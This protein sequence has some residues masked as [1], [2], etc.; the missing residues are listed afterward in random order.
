MFQFTALSGAQS[1]SRASQSILELDGGVKILVDIGWDERFDT[2]QL[3]EL[4]KHVSTLSFILLTHATISHL[5]AYAHCCK[6]IPLFSQVPVYATAPVIAFGR[7][8]LQDLYSSAPAAA[9]FIPASASPED[10]TATDDATR[11][12]ILREAPTFEEINTY[13]SAITPLKYSQPHQP[14]ASY[15]STPLEGLTLTAYNA[16]H[17]LGG[18]IWHIQHGMESIV[19]AV[20]WHQGRENVIAGA[21]WFEGI[22]GSDVSEALRKPTALVCNSI[23][24]GKKARD[25]ALLGHIRSCLSRGGSVLIPTDSS[26]RILE[27]AW[28][29]EKVW[30]EGSN[31]ENLKNAKV[32]MATKSAHATL[33]HARS[34]LEWM[35]DSIVREFEGEEENTNTT[36]KSH[37]RSKSKQGNA[38]KPLRPFEF[39]HVKIVETQNRLERVLKGE[40]PRVIV[41]SD[42]SAEWGY[43]RAALEHIAQNP[44]NVVI[45][46]ERV[47]T[48]STKDMATASTLGQWQTERLNGVALEKS[49]SGDQIE[50]IHTG[51]ELVYRE[52]KRV[53]LDEAELSKYQQY[54]ATQKQIRDSLLTSDGRQLADA[55]DAMAEDDESSSE[56]ED[57]EDEQQ[58]RV[59]NVSA[60]LT[61]GNRNKVALSDEDLGVSILLRKK[62]VFDFD[63]RNK[64]GRNAVFPYAHSR[65]RG[66]EFGDFIKPEDFLREEEREA[67]EAML[68]EKNNSVLGQKRKWSEDKTKQVKSNKKQKAEPAADGAGDDA[69]SDESDSDVE[70]EGAGTE[71][72]LPGKVIYEEKRINFQARLAFVDFAGLHDQ[73]GLQ[74]LIP[75]INPKKL[76][77]VGGSASETMSLANDCKA[78]LG[79]RVDGAENESKAE[80]YAPQVGDMIDASVDTN[81]WTVK[82]TRDLVK[83]LQWQNVRNMSIVTISGQLRAESTPTQ[84]EEEAGSKKLKLEDGSK[85]V[86][87][88]I[89][90]N[91]KHQIQPVLD[92]IPASAAASLRVVTQP[93]HVGDLRL[94]DL[95]RLMRES[96][97]SAVF[98]GEGTLLIDD[99]VAVRKLASGRIV[100]EGPPV[101]LVVRNDSFTQVKQKIY[102]GLA[103]VA[104]G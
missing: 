64:K 19:Y 59:L 46:T 94:A 80:V 78:L 98:R 84:A 33:R 75:L 38:A 90:T 52:A 99:M 41:A 45:L 72:Q 31:D 17:T 9:T 62:D 97:H 39:R 23:V 27:L 68:D 83:R 56:S 67:Q 87:Q 54:M 82:L 26:A 25:E 66:D 77:L 55:E 20:D 65:K 53:A 32:Y 58:G 60:A 22:G 3:A 28:L 57:E 10:Q 42:L 40:G 35:D 34:L 86:E 103:V 76:I 102:D 14:A 47:S 96:G 21:A 37:K 85:K 49:L 92:A 91:N 48:E 101:N 104:A 6:H 51:K 95:R 29:L 73:R 12:N 70:A 8:T 5:G 2:R 89:Q 30:Q 100:V 71:Q 74:M 4:E 18:T 7:T 63:V 43:S 69:S 93:I 13:F 61:H 11:S 50:Q 79:V 36:V 1:T 88:E 44:D 24:G 81:A 15:F 16:G